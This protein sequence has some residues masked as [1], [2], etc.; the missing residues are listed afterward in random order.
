MGLF[1][2]ARHY[3]TFAS[4]YSPPSPNGK[5][6]HDLGVFIGQKID[7]VPGVVADWANRACGW[8]RGVYNSWDTSQHSQ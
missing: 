6:A 2:P 5:L 1:S 3:I 8:A 7:E 4:R